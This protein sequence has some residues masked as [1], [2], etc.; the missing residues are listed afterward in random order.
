MRSA[1][2]DVGVLDGRREFAGGEGVEAAETGVEFGG[3]EA[4]IAVERAEKVGG[5]LFPFLGI[6][7]QTTGNQVEVGVAAGLDAGPDVVEALGVSVGAA[8]AIKTVTAFAKVDGVAQ[9]AGLEEVEFFEVERRERVGKRVQVERRV[10]VGGEGRVH[11]VAHIDC[12]RHGGQARICGEHLLG[13]AHFEDVAGFAALDDAERAEDGEA[14][15]GFADGAGADA[16]SASEPGHGAVELELAFEAR[17]ANEIEIDGAVHDRQAQARV[18]KV[19]ELH[20]EKFEV[21][22]FGVHG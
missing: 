13:Q 11:G 12:P 20:P 14:A 10:E 15:H 9:G 6:A 7:F 2:G 17:V 1:N 16:E 8:Q 18:E 5:G 21:E 19:S 22:F 3:G 4:A